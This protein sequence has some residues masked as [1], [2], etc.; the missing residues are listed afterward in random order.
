MSL[1]K[2]L[3]WGS[4]IISSGSRLNV[5]GL[6][7]IVVFQP[8]LGIVSLF[9][10][11]REAHLSETPQTRSK[12]PCHKLSVSSPSYKMEL[13]LY[14]YGNS[15]QVNELDILCDVPV[16]NECCFVVFLLLT[17]EISVLLLFYHIQSLL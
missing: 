5:V 17:Y 14:P 16:F 1:V 3:V 10:L 15:S 11:S 7:N 4:P 6:S 2:L 13:V 9:F 8:D 12:R